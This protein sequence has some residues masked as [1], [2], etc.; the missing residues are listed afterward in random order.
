MTRINIYTSDD[1][2]AYGY[3]KPSLLGWFDPATSEAFEQDTRWDGN[4][5][6][7]VITGSQWVDECLYR[8]KG[9]KWVRNNNA[10]R[11]MGGPNTF[12][13]LA[14]DEARDWLLRSECNDEAIERFFGDVAEEED[15]RPGRPTIGEP[16]GVRLGD[17]LPAIDEFAARAGLKRAAAVRR[18][19]A[20][21]LR[22]VT[23]P[24]GM[25]PIVVE[26]NVVT[27]RIEID[28]TDDWADRDARWEFIVDR[29]S[30]ASALGV[31]VEPWGENEFSMERA[32]QAV[33]DLGYTIGEWEGEAG[34]TW[35]AVVT[36]RA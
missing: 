30:G 33:R 12:E 21:G 20:I 5:M 10:T 29:C 27:G 8:T 1:E 6:V 7:G 36:G 17:H 4:N 25:Q 13:F 35:R 26:C 3:G 28:G 19:A 14:D 18:L 32:G 22:A 24:P 34:G 9:G 23:L 11:Y 16:V 31:T 15:R 2:Q